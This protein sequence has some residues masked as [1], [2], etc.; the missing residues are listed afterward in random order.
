MLKIF[1]AY[2]G[3]SSIVICPLLFIFWEEM[4]NKRYIKKYYKERINN[5]RELWSGDKIVNKYGEELIYIQ[6]NSHYDQLKGYY[7]YILS[8]NKEIED[9]LLFLQ[10]V[11]HELYEIKYKCKAR[12]YRYEF[13]VPD[14]DHE[15]LKKIFNYLRQRNMGVLISQGLQMDQYLIKK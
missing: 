15:L 5:L 12:Y 9:S 2:A 10:T 1:F 6:P 3:L 7:K 11:K 8:N 4:N 13:K 14:K